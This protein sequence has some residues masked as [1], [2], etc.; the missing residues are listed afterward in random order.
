MSENLLIKWDRKQ[1]NHV[2]LAWS[3]D[4]KITVLSANEKMFTVN[5][6]KVKR[7]NHV[8]LFITIT[9]FFYPFLWKIIFDIDRFS[10]YSLCK[11]TLSYNSYSW[12]SYFLPF[13][14]FYWING[15]YPSL[16]CPMKGNILRDTTSMT[17]LMIE[18][19]TYSFTL[20]PKS[21]N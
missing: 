21:F 12:R 18:Y 20:L 5:C 11:W 15:I 6:F 3:Y 2:S 13:C 10:V 16:L 9:T 4:L 7:R 17:I 8:V 19:V 14:V 1:W